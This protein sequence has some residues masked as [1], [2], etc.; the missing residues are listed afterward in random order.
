MIDRVRQSFALL[1]NSHRGWVVL[2][3]GSAL[4]A[5][6][7]EASGL[8]LVF[9]FFSAALAPE[10]LIVLPV[11]GPMYSILGFDSLPEFLAFLSVLIVIAFLL[12]AGFL[13]LATWFSQS[14]RRRLQCDLAS[15][16]FRAYLKQPLVWHVRKGSSRLLNNVANNISQVVQHMIIAALD[17]VAA[18]VTLIVLLV[19]LVWLKPLETMIAVLSIGTIAWLFLAICRSPLQRWGHLTVSS[20]E[21]VWRFIREPLQGIKTVKVQRVEEYFARRVE[22][23]VYELLTLVLK[24]S[25]IQQAPRL[26][27]EVFLVSGI[28]FIVAVAFGT[29]ATAASIIPAMVL[30]AGAASRTLPQTTAIMT[31]LQYMRTSEGALDTLRE[32]MVLLTTSEDPVYVCGQSDQARP[33]FKTLELENIT[34]RYGPDMQ[35]ALNQASL[36]LHSGEL[37]A[38]VGLSG[39][40]KTTIADMLLGLLK[41]ESGRLLIDN[42]VTPTFPSSLFAYVP[43]E[44]FIIRDS[45]RMNIALTDEIIDEEKVN[46]AVRAASLQKV[47][48]R[49]PQ[50]LDTIMPEDGGG[51]S[52]GERQRLALARAL[53]VD[54]PV[55]ILDE[56][57]ASLD[58]LTEAEIS[59]TLQQF[60][61]EKT[62]V[63]IAH[64][65]STVKNFDRV[66]YM[67]EGKVEDEGS[68]SQ[69]YDR[70]SNFR[71]MVDFLSVHVNR[72]T[73]DE[74][75]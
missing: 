28:L 25:L 27:L 49:L 6:I 54:A 3:L 37:V 36:E 66:V 12:R 65:L 39:A 41:P 74:K 55:L 40:G 30:F 51:L 32:D 53:Y 43:Q 34:F 68:F 17:I 24:K 20:S 14:F 16:F 35:P 44:P 50:G 58:A 70:N 45:L 21:A 29:G 73:T 1:D 60:R 69:L 48:L 23:S 2:Y 57:T 63:L 67:S 7:L 8:A 61:G 47:V 19:T 10:K 15:K 38:L 75:V 11:I 9:G 64:R 31:H 4:L 13:I 5:A 22:A 46:R 62:I 33:P 52:G 71:T 18:G 42:E 59:N 72:T 56:P 26:V